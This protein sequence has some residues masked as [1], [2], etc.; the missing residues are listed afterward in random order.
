MPASFLNIVQVV[1]SLCLIV[2]ILLQRR[3]AGLSTAFGGSGGGYYTRRGFERTLFIAS[4]I[5]GILFL[6]LALLQLLV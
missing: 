5:I 2:V 4:I 6:L 1:V 3:G